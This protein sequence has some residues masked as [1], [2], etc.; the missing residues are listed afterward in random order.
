MN[1]SSFMESAG[2]NSS[3]GGDDVNVTLLWGVN[4]I[5]SVLLCVLE[6]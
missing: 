6:G 3:S 1:S 4:V 2:S 5:A